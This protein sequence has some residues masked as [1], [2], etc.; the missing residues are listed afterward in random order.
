MLIVNYEIVESL[1]IVESYVG[2][3]YGSA[4]EI[5]ADKPKDS[6]RVRVC[7][8]FIVCIITIVCMLVKV[9]PAILPLPSGV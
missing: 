2:V 3:L 9:P 7:I 1:E 8:V 6:S 4:I 5:A